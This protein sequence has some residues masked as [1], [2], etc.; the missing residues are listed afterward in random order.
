VQVLSILCEAVS[1]D[2]V[3]DCLV[4][5]DGA[6]GE[7]ALR[8]ALAALESAG[9][10]ERTPTGLRCA[11][12]L[13]EV[14]TREAVVEGRYEPMARAVKRVLPVALAW[15]RTPVF[16][17]RDQGLR[18]VRIAFYRQD[19]RALQQVLWEYHRQFQADGHSEPPLVT[20][21]ARPFD[22]DWFLA[23]T[24]P[25]RSAAAGDIL[26]WSA[27][28][29]EPCTDLLRCLEQDRVPMPAAVRV[30]QADVYILQGRFAEAMETLGE[31][32][33]P[34]R[35]VRLA[36]LA[37]LRGEN[38]QAVAL[39]ESGLHDLRREQSKA[40]AYYRSYGGLFHL[41]ALLKSR[42]P[43][44]QERL[45]AC[46][47]AAE[48]EPLWRETCEAIRGVVASMGGG[49]QSK[50][51]LR[52]PPEQAPDALALV[53]LACVCLAQ[54]KALPAE[55]LARL[56]LRLRE[57][58]F[59]WA[60]S[61]AAAML[62]A[63]T[64]RDDARHYAHAFRTRTG[65][66]GLVGTVVLYEAWERA[67][68]ALAAL[69][70]PPSAVEEPTA[71]TR[72][73][74]F[75][76]LG[77]TTAAPPAMRPAEQHR[78]AK[79]AW[80]RGR[81]VP[82][83]DLYTLAG[84][85]AAMT[86]Q[87]HRICAAI[88]VK[89]DRWKPD[90]V[91]YA[92]RTDL[93]LV[94][95]VGH[96][97]LF[98]EDNPRVRLELVQGEPELIIR[99]SGETIELSMVP[100]CAG[101]ERVLLLRD[102]PT[103]VR[104]VRLEETHRRVSAI[105]QGGLRL[106]AHAREKV[107]EAVAPLAARLIVQSDIG[108]VEAG[109]TAVPADPTIHVHLLPT[110]DGLTVELLVQ[111]FGQR[112]PTYVPARGGT[113]VVADVGGRRL[114]TV[115]DVLEELGRAEAVPAACPILEQLPQTDW[116]WHVESPEECLD[117]LLQ[118][119]A[120]P[121]AVQ[122]EWP[123]GR[124]V[125]VS[126]MLDLDDLHLCIRRQRD[127][128][129]VSGDVPVNENLTLSLTELIRLAAVTPGRFIPLGDGQY[130]ALTDEFRKRIEELALLGE[131]RRE[132][133][134]FHPLAAAAVDGIV[135]EAGYLDADQEWRESLG[136]LEAA[137][138]LEPTLPTAL[139]AELRDYQVE[140]YRWLLRLAAWGAGGCL[141]D[142]MGLGKT[143]QA[144]SA[145]LSRASLGPS[146]V[147]APTSVCLNWRDE[148]AR[149][150]PTL[151]IR[152]FG[153]GDRQEMLD[154]LGPNDLVICSYGLMQTGR[155]ALAGIEW[156]TVVLDEAQAIKNP[157]AKRSQ[158][159]FRLSGAFRVITTGTPIEN[160]LSELWSL[161]RFINPG[162]LGTLEHFNERFAL[163]IER[164]GDA[165]VRQR[166]RRLIAP[167]MLRRT[168]R[169]VL[170]E[171]PPRTEVLQHVQL[172]ERERAFYEALR[173]ESLRRI[174]EQQGGPGA[175]R[176]QILAEI[177]RLRQAC[178]NPRLILPGCDIDSAKLEAFDGIVEELLANAHKALVFSQFVT[179]LTIIREHLDRKG[180]RYQYL[181]GSTAPKERAER[182]AAFQRGEGDLFLISL[183]AGGTG[184]NLTA[185]DYVIHLDPWWNP[186]VEDQ[187]SD[188]AHRI[189]QY[190]PVTI[191]R[192]VAADTIEDR[193]V[194]LHQRKR[195]LADSLLSGNEVPTSVS[196]EELLRL[197]SQP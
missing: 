91:E 48:A 176:M 174:G 138:H 63:V 45:E 97:L 114:E 104:L 69:G 94:E 122:V 89:A 172:S 87:D 43:A 64:G 62:A 50:G 21:C 23:L 3:R 127:W 151:S 73:V 38:E 136:R 37:F 75:V 179:H 131:V 135:R 190:Q 52:L 186:A 154:N 165:E 194:E 15:N 185:A 1:E 106:P 80:T 35:A 95:M 182:V 120:L 173:R 99:E 30:F 9:Q 18:E 51:D 119:R 163:P 160:N 169:Q 196:A 146:L 85:P 132:G 8:S 61:E 71:E 118:L 168:K 54:P 33:G 111:P 79:G 32:E 177:T 70:Q 19:S 39:F 166:L 156:Q 153:E 90:A 34:A 143:V 129:G 147:V 98:W 117:L 25:M 72:F 24:A 36:W 195:D 149:F 197:M 44:H 159:A 16:R 178:C 17:T 108:S 68:D 191:Y 128:F 102:T 133:L 167:F 40:D 105:L 180:A 65:V 14:A 192:L 58:G 53:G 88:T 78:T 10:I 187:A 67:L 189:G 47:A 109:T 157:R 155:E 42:M 123:E 161:F 46:L 11:P 56:W 170:S 188:R 142:D 29:L 41:L 158:A 82:L 137:R 115:R 27:L 100:C 121:A 12:G 84:R 124:T 175:R 83:A 86:E 5:A 144:L 112:G 101:D 20:L 92:F 183:K 193:I 171:L 2:V 103:R 31:V 22:R 126:R 148:A 59:E 181:D 184:L 49:D 81:T 130:L 141:A 140:G 13:R 74:W 152:L 150:T 110:G 107:R 66:T 7:E 162:L 164:D 57:S 134:R 96:P 76:K 6:P 145:I 139:R 55:R 93:A 116:T 125:S 26:A 113:T 77:E 4:Q 28:R 60:A